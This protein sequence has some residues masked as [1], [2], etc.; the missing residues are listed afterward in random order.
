MSSGFD[1]LERQFMRARRTG[2]QAIHYVNLVPFVTAEAS[3]KIIAAMHRCL[4][5][6]ENFSRTSVLY[7][8]VHM[9]F[10]YFCHIAVF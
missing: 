5:F 6:A 7:S 10:A 4:V 3:A 8:T 9:L 1:C 2:Y